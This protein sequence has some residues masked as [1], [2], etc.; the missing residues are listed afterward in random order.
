MTTHR[1]FALENWIDLLERGRH[2]VALTV[3]KIYF[4]LISSQMPFDQVENASVILFQYTCVI[5]PSNL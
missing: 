5:L 2:S 4:C 3:A 1:T